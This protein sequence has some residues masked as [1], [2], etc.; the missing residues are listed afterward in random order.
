M[1]KIFLIFLGSLLLN[2]SFAQ[3]GTL[4]KADKSYELLS[5]SSAIPMYEQLLGSKLDSPILKA[6]LARS[7]YEIGNNEIAEKLYRQALDNKDLIPAEHF[8]YFSNT[9][10]RVG[11]YAESDEWLLSYKQKVDKSLIVDNYNLNRDYLQHILN[12]KGHFSIGTVQFNSKAADFGAY[13]DKNNDYLYFVSSRLNKPVRRTYGWNGDNFLDLYVIKGSKTSN[14]TRLSKKINSNYHEGPLCFAGNTVYFTRN[15]ISKGKDKRDSKGIQNL[16]LYKASVDKEGKW[17]SITSINLNSKEYSI[18]HPSI[19]T[20]GKTLFFVSDMPG[21]FGG[22]DLYKAQILTDGNLGTPVNLGSV[23]NTEGNEMFP[24]I[25]PNGQLFFS[26]NGLP[27]LGGL[28]IFVADLDE[29]SNVRSFKHCGPE[30]NS[31]KDDFGVSFLAEG[32]TGYFSSDRPGGLGNDDIYTFE[33]LKPFVF[34]LQLKGQVTEVDTKIV[35][36]GTEVILSDTQGN[37][38]AKAIADENGSYGFIIDPG[39]EYLLAFNE[40]GHVDRVLNA[41]ANTT[42]GVVEINAEL[43]KKP[44]F[45][46]LCLINDAADNTA[47]AGVDLVV[48]NITTGA[49]L[50]KG[51]TD[52]K[53]LIKTTLENVKIGDQLKLEVTIQKEGYLSK[54]VNTNVVISKPGYINL[55][56]LMNT[57]L[58]KIEIGLDLTNIIDIKP[59]YFDLGKYVIR[60]DAALELDKI[61]KIMN[62]YPSM[63]IELGS[64]TDC[65]GS[66]TSNA[67]LSNNRAKAS[68]DYI[69]KRITNPERIYGKGYGESKLKVDCPCEGSVKST[70]SEEE[71]QKNRRTEFIIVKM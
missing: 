17:N 55:H 28:D 47:L 13:Y 37:I 39:K 68:A 63:E 34:Q 46:I 31:N 23:I 57:S 36:P 48:K 10:K 3:I 1:N 67:T 15:N 4:K 7:H 9:L 64:H 44:D 70:C 19:S 51:K 30:I 71:H 22:S 54:S 14:A 5:Y 53:G 25:A 6:K 33:L 62:D 66:I 8:L 11:K 16:M 24:W 35:L 43:S 61:V 69:K 29:E 52:S 2:F 41:F 38:I 65:R 58:G 60:K 49:E 56:E 21:G 40:S 50:L 59:I 27:G 32:K 18:G 45:G 12:N 42:S 26:S 20:D